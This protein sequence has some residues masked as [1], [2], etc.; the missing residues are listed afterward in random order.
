MSAV[1]RDRVWLHE[2]N[3]LHGRSRYEG[4]PHLGPT[5]TKSLATPLQ[6]ARSMLGHSKKIHCFP[7]VDFI[8]AWSSIIAFKLMFYLLFA[9]NVL[10]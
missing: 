9:L 1:R 3:D 2:T 5:V 7:H 6:G 4:V 8:P 10:V